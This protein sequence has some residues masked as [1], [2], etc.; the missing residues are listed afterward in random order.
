MTRICVVLVALTVAMSARAQSVG[1][2]ETGIT[3]VYSDAL[4]RHVTAS[5]Q[6]YDKTKLTAAHRTLPFG[7]TIK[8]TNLKNHTSVVLRVNDRGPFHKDRIL[9]ISAAAAVHLGFS[10]LGV[11]EVTLEVIEVGSG[12]RDIF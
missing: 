4:D 9:D 5:G 12:R 11:G 2:R 7:T 8:V 3:A 10:R 1:D 6:L